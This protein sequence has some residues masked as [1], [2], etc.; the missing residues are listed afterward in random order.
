MNLLSNKNK[1]I[2]FLDKNNNKIESKDKITLILSPEFYWLRV[3]EIP[4]KS[5]KSALE[6]VPSLFE[7]YLPLNNYTYQVKKIKDNKFLCFAFSNDEVF[8]AIKNLGVSLNLVESIYFAQN[9]F[10]S[11]ESFSINLNTYVYSNDILVKV[12]ANIV[13]NDCVNLDKNLNS[14]KLSRDKVNL[15][16]Y[17]NVLPKKLF[18]VFLFSLIFLSIVN[19][20]KNIV[21]SNEIQNNEAQ[22]LL[23]KKEYKLPNTIIQTKSIIKNYDKKIKINIKYRELI[24]YLIQYKRISQKVIFQEININKKS[25]ILYVK[26]VDIIKFKNHIN[27]KY[28]KATSSINANILRMEIIL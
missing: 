2:Y 26:N 18:F 11:Y 5:A 13:I 12:P 28:K 23:L 21:Y 22:I 3:F 9:E 24:K 17:K 27:K 20:S 6:V 14:L 1:I 8:E 10:T 16:L 25:F 4:V 7:D 15:K 19:L